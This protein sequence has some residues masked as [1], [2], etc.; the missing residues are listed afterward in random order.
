MPKRLLTAS[1]REIL[2]MNGRD[3]LQAIQMSEGRTIMVSARTRSA[4][5]VDGV[6]NAEVA[7][8]FGADLILL[9]TY[10]PLNPYVPGLPSVDPKHDEVTRDVQVLMGR[11]RTL[12]DVRELI[13]R[14]V[15]VLLSFAT[16]ESGLR[17]H[18]G[19]IE[20]TEE[21]ARRAVEQGAD[22]IHLGGWAPPQSALKTV[23]TVRRA[24]GKEVIVEYARPHGPGIIGA[25][26]SFTTSLFP[27]NEIEA[28]LDIG[29]D[30]IG[31]PAP[32]T[33][34]GWTV[35]HVA[36]LAEFIHRKG[37]LVSL[38]IHTSQEG[39][40][41]DTLRQIALWAKMAGADIY[42][43]GDSGFN[44]CLIPPENILNVS[45][46]VRGRRHTYRRMAFSP[47]R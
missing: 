5:L 45:I 39:S 1:P 31:L 40:D 19:N 25:V 15:G 2:S 6:T 44:E 38:G 14:P 41:V 16:E 7:A 22:F 35:D 27:R 36:E 47:L 8:A 20:A 28:A 4:N 18:Y 23:E 13:G 3:L 37:R 9:D 17:N 21:R 34:P 12:R 10:D 32:G 29:V 11:G 26:S 33:F 42:E 46:A 43:L 30:V 24:V